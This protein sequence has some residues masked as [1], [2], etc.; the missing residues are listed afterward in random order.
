[1]EFHNLLPLDERINFFK[2]LRLP[3]IKKL[4]LVNLYP[5]AHHTSSAS[6]QTTINL[7]TRINV[8]SCSILTINRMDVRWIV[9]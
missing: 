7:L 3:N 9:L 4:S 8:K 1:M 2:F 6:R 5:L